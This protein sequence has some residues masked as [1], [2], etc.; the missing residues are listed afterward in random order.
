M[1]H[2]QCSRCIHRGKLHH[3]TILN[4]ICYMY[5]SFISITVDATRIRGCIKECT[6]MY[7][8][9]PSSWNCPTATIFYTWIQTFVHIHCNEDWIH[10]SFQQQRFIS[11]NAANRCHSWWISLVTFLVWIGS[12]CTWC[13]RSFTYGSLDHTENADNKGWGNLWLPFNVV[14]MGLKVLDQFVKIILVHHVTMGGQSRLWQAAIVRA[15]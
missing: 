11:E 10:Q 12:L 13:K 2:I 8:N 9:P 5:W 14:H 4:T 3:R 6:P 15:N 1:N 7:P